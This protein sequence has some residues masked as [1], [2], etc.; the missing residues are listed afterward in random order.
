VLAW[1]LTGVLAS[2]VG[3]VMDGIVCRPPGTA[4]RTVPRLTASVAATRVAV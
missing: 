3:S 1:V 4:R 2:V